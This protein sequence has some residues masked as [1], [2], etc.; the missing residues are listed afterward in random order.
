MS[1]MG[2]LFGVCVLPCDVLESTFVVLG[3]SQLV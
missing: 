1:P 3:A 2:Q